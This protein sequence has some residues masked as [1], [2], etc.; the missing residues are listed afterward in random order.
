M[1][2]FRIIRQDSNGNRFIEALDLTEVAANSFLSIREKQIGAHH[3]TVWKVD[4]NEDAPY[5]LT[6]VE[7]KTG[8]S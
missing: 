8:L 6:L 1:T 2:K 5:P 7:M 4:M 3:Q